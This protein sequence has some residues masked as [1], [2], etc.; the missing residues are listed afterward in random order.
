MEAVFSHQFT[1]EGFDLDVFFYDFSYI[2][3]RLNGT[4]NLPRSIVEQC[5]IFKNMNIAAVFFHQSASA[6]IYSSVPK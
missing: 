3:H 6:H 1:P 5:G 2:C 4:H